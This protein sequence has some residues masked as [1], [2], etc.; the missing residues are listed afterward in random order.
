MTAEVATTPRQVFD[1][2][3]YRRFYSDRPVHDARRIGQLAGG[4]TGMSAWW[5]VP[6]RR[7]LDVGAGTGLWRDWFAREKPNVTYHS[8]DVSPYACRRYGHEQADITTWQPREPADLVV[9]QGVLQ[10]IDDAGCTRAIANL[11][12]ACAAVLYLEVPTLGD[13]DEVIDP[14]ATDLDIHWRTGA[15]YR[16]RLRRH[17]N[18]VGG[19]LFVARAAGLHFYELEMEPRRS[20]RTGARTQATAASRSSENT[21]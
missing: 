20:A 5:E 8:V 19:G 13:R 11:A 12:A 7:V 16:Q 15:W 21:R 9:C 1:A 2:A 18:A 17:F 14:D 6:I 4:V 3:Y 10:Y